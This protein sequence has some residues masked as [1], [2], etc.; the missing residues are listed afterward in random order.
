MST[1]TVTEGNTS[2]NPYAE[3][4]YDTPPEP[5][6]G[7]DLE[8]NDVISSVEEEDT[9]PLYLVRTVH[10]AQETINMDEVLENM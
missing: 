8:D 3:E 6:N 1:R 7:E 2:P 10:R 5:D 9:L 4:A